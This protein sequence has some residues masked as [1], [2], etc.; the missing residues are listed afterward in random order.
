VGSSSQVW[1]MVMSFG[2]NPFYKNER[3]SAVCA[4]HISAAA[5]FGLI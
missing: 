2:W 4:F 1:P 3:R 5:V